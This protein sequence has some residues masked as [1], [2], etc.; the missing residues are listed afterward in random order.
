MG[1]LEFENDDKK[2]R[3]FWLDMKF[4]NSMS[5]NKKEK[6]ESTRGRVKVQIDVLTAEQADANPVGKARQ[7]PNH[8]PMLP[9]PEG[10]VSLTINPFKMWEQMIGP[11]IRKRIYCMLC[12]IMCVVACIMILPNLFGTIITT[13][14]SSDWTDFTKWIGS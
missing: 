10:R 1:P 6:E 7:E 12:C 11:A 3:R 14:I 2:C 9:Q 13:S 5:K 4:K 8:S